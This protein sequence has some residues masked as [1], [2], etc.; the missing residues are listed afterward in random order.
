[1]IRQVIFQLARLGDMLQTRRLMAT[2]HELGPVMLVVD[3]SLAGLAGRAYPEAE[4]VPVSAHRAGGAHPA[5]SVLACLD[6]VKA[7]SPE[8][9]YLLNQGGMSQA[10]ATAFDQDMVRGHHLRRGQAHSD[11]W[12]EY[13]ARATAQRRAAGINIA[14]YWAYFAGQPVAPEHVNPVAFE[15]GDDLGVALAG[16]ESRRSPTPEILAQAVSGAYASLPGGG[17]ANGRI[18]LL[19]TADQAPLA[20]RLTRLLPPLLSARTVDLTGKT[21]LADLPDLVAGLGRLLSPDTGLAHLAAFLGVPVTGLYLS[22]AWCH[23]TGPY[24]LGHV[25]WQAVP[26]CAP[27][28]ESAAC[29][30][31]L[32][33]HRPFG[34]ARLSRLVAGAGLEPPVGMVGLYSSFDELG[35]VYPAA[36][37]ED[38]TREPRAR[39]RALTKGLVCAAEPPA[40]FETASTWLTPADW[41][42]HRLDG[43]QGVLPPWP[44]AVFAA[45]RNT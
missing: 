5:H 36:S 37:G 19:G 17:A 11:R 7:F 42:L 33:C 41:M 20:R 1:M 12:C 10:L 6:R 44:S 9:V 40:D 22:S 43:P 13:V 34:D 15:R 27:C 38:P 4:I 25:V 32:V 28:L 24:G 21:A 39:F 29:P 30:E 18:L 3:A 2:A 16:R 23:E 26:G 14:D 31:S 35:A 45:R 8:R